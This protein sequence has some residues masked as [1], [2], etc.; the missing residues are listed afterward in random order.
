[1]KKLSMLALTAVTALAVPCIT[2]AA[3]SGSIKPEKML[4]DYDRYAVV[5]TGEEER[6]Y[7]DTESL[8]RDPMNAGSLPIIRGTL[9]AEVYRDPLTY[10]DYG[11]YDLVKYILRYDIAIGA[12]QIGGQIRYRMQDDLVGAYDAQGRPIPAPVL[13]DS[14]VDEP[15]DLYIALYR[16]TRDSTGF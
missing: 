14:P 5:Y 13:K 4:N 11:N 3:G 12:D 7:A 15:D 1:M 10:P 6:V 9:Y 16:L 8:L 2:F